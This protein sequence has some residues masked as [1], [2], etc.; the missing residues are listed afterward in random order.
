MADRS[1]SVRL[2]LDIGDY[3]GN[4]KAAAEATT[5]IA[6][7]AEK[8]GSDGQAAFE[9]LSKAGREVGT[10]LLAIGGVAAAGV[11]AIAVGALSAGLAYNSLE[12]RARAALETV[13]GSTE[14]ANA[15]MDKLVEFGSTS[16]FPRQVWIEAQQT[17]LGFGMEAERVIPTLSAIQDGVVAVGGGTQEIQGIVEVL[18]RVQS[19]GNV[20]ADTLR[21]LG[22]RGVD[23][24]T[25]IG[26]SMGRTAQQV[27]DDISSGAIDAET[28]LV[29]LTDSMQARFEGAADGLRETWDGAADRVG[30]ALRRIG[31]DMAA[32]FITPTG[33][34][35]LVD[36][37]NAVADALGSFEIAAQDLWAT[38]GERGQPAFDAITI[39][40]QGM[41]NAIA[42]VDLVAFLDHIN[43]GIPV[44]GGLAA[45][46]AAAGSASVLS[47]I[48]M[49]SLATAISPLTAGLAA[50]TLLS[51]ELRGLFATLLE[52][53]LPLAVALADT[54]ALVAG[55]VAAAIG[56]IAEFITPVIETIGMLVQAFLALPD[57]VN[58]AVLAI[59]GFLVALRFWG[60]I[61]A[62]VAGLA[63]LGTHM[64]SLSDNSDALQISVTGLADDLERLSETGQVTAD[65]ER[66]FGAGAEGAENF[67]D[68]LGVASS[69]IESW[70]NTWNRSFDEMDAADD[71]FRTLDSAMTQLVESG[72]DADDILNALID[73][74]DLTGDQVDELIE[75]LPGYVSAAERQTSATADAAS[76][77]AELAGEIGHANAAMQ[78]QT[79]LL[80]EQIDPMFNLI[81]RLD[82]VEDKQKA[83]NEAVEEYGEDSKE[84]SAASMDHFASLVDLEEAIGEA[85]GSFDGE[86]TPA[87]RA[88][89]VAGGMTEAQIDDVERELREAAAAGEDYTGDYE[90]EVTLSGD[91]DVKRRFRELSQI[92]QGIERTI[93]IQMN[94]VGPGAAPSPEGISAPMLPFATG[95]RVP[96]LGRTG[97]D[98]VPALLTADEHV[99]TPDEVHGAG[100]HAAV[101]ALRAA[102][103]AGQ[104]SHARPMA[105]TTSPSAGSSGV[106]VQQMHID[107]WSDRFDLRQVQAELALTGAV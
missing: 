86:L 70:S 98:K 94:I 1:L 68:K 95:G 56:G 33:G 11:A 43:S 97:I 39:G 73:T 96:S 52:S 20:T 106:T 30:G 69:G 34:G 42:D 19:T 26:D 45:A 22:V 63:S 88:T 17:L 89:M 40:L 59:G 44:L 51:P 7:G 10:S 76:E 46:A 16:P 24:A 103:L 9:Q 101:E 75:L 14:A 80:R 61:G 6:E 55:P 104:T 13:L 2:S 50:L 79:A 99:W 84:A 92:A 28:F 90:A 53:L 81:R 64:L 91:E 38:L 77:Q 65:L 54:A 41:A 71:A 29:S 83:Y 93:D 4:A 66:L 49:T 57:P 21:Q 78:E 62:A 74:Y 37:A 67:A 3:K 47:A 102:S 107:A 87:M 25:L 60:P 8:A 35:A 12:Q 18:A 31:S 15:Q 58:S 5:S 36:W 100:G 82:E 72:H 48:G 85:A 23:A 105:P 27:R 32:A